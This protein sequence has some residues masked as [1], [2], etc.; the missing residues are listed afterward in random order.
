MNDYFS[1]FLNSELL[2]EI[3]DNGRSLI[4]VIFRKDK[5]IEI[6]MKRS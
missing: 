6:Y 1:L 2:K 5:N 4:K 3:I